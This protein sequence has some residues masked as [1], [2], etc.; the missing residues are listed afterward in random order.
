MKWSYDERWGNFINIDNTLHTEKLN[1]SNHYTLEFW[2]KLK[3]YPI[4]SAKGRLNPTLVSSDDF[5]VHYDS[6]HLIFSKDLTTIEYPHNEWF[7]FVI[8]SGDNSKTASDGKGNI[9]VNGNLKAN[10]VELPIN[11]GKLWIGKTIPGGKAIR[12]PLYI[13]NYLGILRI[14]NRSLDKYEINNNYYSA[15]KNYGLE[16]T[17]VTAYVKD[18][19]VKNYRGQKNIR[20]KYKSMSELEQLSKLFAKLSQLENLHKHLYLYQSQLKLSVGM[21]KV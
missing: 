16:M 6:K 3:Y 4:I 21:L 12:N 14:Y 8:V 17:K 13:D 11:V 9:Y 7:Q 20:H 19:L 1:L 10:N 18:G 2:V 5:R 15:A